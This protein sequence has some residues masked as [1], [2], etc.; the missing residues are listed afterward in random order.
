MNK[1]E[2][3]AICQNSKCNKDFIVKPSTKGKYCSLPCAISHNQQLSYLKRVD[4]Y[5]QNP[6]QCLQC[7]NSLEY[8]QRH[9]NKFCSSSCSATYNNPIKKLADKKLTDKKSKNKLCKHNLCLHCN[10]LLLTKTNNGKY[11]SVK[12]QQQYYRITIIFPKITAGLVTKRHTLKKYLIDQHSYKCSSCNNTEWMEC[13]IPLEV[14]HIDG[15]AGNNFPDNLRLLCPNCHALTST[16]K[17]K[18]KG[19]GRG[20]RGIKR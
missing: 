19:N 18:N 1:N 20:S 13:P 4:E 7:N 12:C 10:N 17:N 8:K 11:C 5:N 14:D 3:I 9:E 15:N 6:K 2:R 16:Y